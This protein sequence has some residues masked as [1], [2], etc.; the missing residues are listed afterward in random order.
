MSFTT[1]CFVRV[2]DAKERKE[3]IGWLQDIGYIVHVNGKIR[4]SIVTDSSIGHA[5][6]GNW[7]SYGKRHNCGSNIELFKALAAMNDENDYHQYFRHKHN[8]YRWLFCNGIRLFDVIA[9]EENWRK[10]TAEEIVEHFKKMK[11]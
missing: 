5:Y 8:E 1:P 4:N 9:L 10:A 11:V 2:E 6:V 3:L 7:S